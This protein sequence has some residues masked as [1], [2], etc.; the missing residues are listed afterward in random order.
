MNVIGAD[1]EANG[2][3]HLMKH[4]AH[5]GRAQ[6]G[7]EPAGIHGRDAVAVCDHLTAENALV[8]AAQ[9]VGECDCDPGDHEDALIR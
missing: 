2:T 1:Q 6:P 7:G 8:D 5:G 4:E 9:D 3:P